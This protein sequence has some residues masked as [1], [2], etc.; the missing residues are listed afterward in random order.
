VSGE[1]QHAP[2]AN[3]KQRSF[4]G[5]VDEKKAAPLDT[6]TR[7]AYDRTLLAYERTLMAWVRTS[8]SLISFGFSIYKFF[9][10]ER[11]T[12]AKFGQPQIVGPRRFA[13]IMIAIGIIALAMATVQHRGQINAIRRVYDGV[14]RSITGWVAALVSVLGILAIFAVIFRL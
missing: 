13:M 10:L 1:E 11:G 9:E 7:L 6:S 4:M 5:N 14:P 3:K 2:T 8:A 12:G